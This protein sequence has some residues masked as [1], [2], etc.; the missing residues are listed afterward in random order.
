MKALNLLVVDNNTS[1]LEVLCQQLEHWG[2]KVQG[3]EDATAAQSLMN[4][5]QQNQQPPFD[6]IFI[7]EALPDMNGI[8]L[9]QQI[10]SNSAWVKVKLVLMTSMAHSGESQHFAQQGFSANFPRPATTSDLFD[11]LAVLLEDTTAIKDASSPAGSNYDH[12]IKA[13]STTQLAPD[14]NSDSFWPDHTRILLVEDNFINQE[15]AKSLLEDMKLSADVASDGQEALAMLNNSTS[16][17]PY[18][19]VLMDC[20]M[21]IMDGY[22]T[23]KNIRQNEAGERYKNIPI[24]A[25]TANA[26]QGDKDKCL[27]EGMSD[28][29]SKPIDPIKLQSLLIKWLMPPNP[30]KQAI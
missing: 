1:N 10:K 26:M 25:L 11:A 24:I 18:T 21:P 7:D 19:L 6:L 2:A 12:F 16:I 3:A 5:H 15:V 23:T 4:E 14:T 29:L 13:S 17:N 20:Q 8:Q 28:Y 9:A 27:K 30:P 22:T